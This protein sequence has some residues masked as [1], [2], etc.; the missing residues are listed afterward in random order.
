VHLAARAGVRQ[1]VGN[2]HLYHRDNIDGTQNLINV[3]KLHNVTKVIYAST[4]S[5]YS[6]TKTL[7]WTEE[8][9]QPHQKNP[10]AYTK[11]VNECQFKM[12]GLHNIGLRFFTVYGPW[13][14]PDMALYDMT[15]NIV[16]GNPVR[17]FNWGLMKRDFTYISDIISGIKLCIFNQDIPSNEIFNIGRGRQVDLMHFINR[18]GIELNRKPDIIKTPPHPADVIETWSNTSK[19]EKIGYQPVV[20][21]EEGVA[22][23]VSW[24]KD[25]HEVN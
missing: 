24:Y 3:C 18:I 25:Y 8:I 21:I 20:D 12:S 22:E 17:A 1:S 11:Y 9:V 7:P 13:G 14:R 4:S 10:Y 15:K 6:G 5:V 16:A 19:I 2:E 23:F